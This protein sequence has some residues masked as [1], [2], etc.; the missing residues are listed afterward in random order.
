MPAIYLIPGI[1]PPDRPSQDHNLPEQG[2]LQVRRQ[3][4]NTPSFLRTEPPPTDHASPRGAAQEQLGLADLRGITRT[5]TRPER[6]TAGWAL[7]HP[8]PRPRLPAPPCTPS[9]HKRRRRQLLAVTIRKFSLELLPVNL[10]RAATQFGARHQ[11]LEQSHLLRNKPSSGAGFH[12]G[13]SAKTAGSESHSWTAEHKDLCSDR[14]AAGKGR[15][16]R[17]RSSGSICGTE[18]TLLHQPNCQND[19]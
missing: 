17:N 4:R 16:R 5:G 3:G 19:F 13:S 6:V 11:L 14:I 12:Q 18:R 9:T 7:P 10:H 15:N 2:W 1:S 8:T